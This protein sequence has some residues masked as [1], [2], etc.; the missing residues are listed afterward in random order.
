MKIF[1]AK[2]L[3]LACLALFYF[4]IIMIDVSIIAFAIAATIVLTLYIHIRFLNLHIK[5]K[6]IWLPSWGWVQENEVISIIL[7]SIILG[8]EGIIAFLIKDF[9]IHKK[10]IIDF[11]IVAILC[12]VICAMIYIY[13]FIK[14]KKTG[15]SYEAH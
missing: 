11:Q 10:M 13:F 4:E 1:V 5:K 12:V 6:L 8:M 7:T 9:F 2:L 15:K 3:C 14:T